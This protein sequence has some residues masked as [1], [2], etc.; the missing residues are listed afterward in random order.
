MP[1]KAAK[2]PAKPKEPAEV[3]NLQ[4]DIRDAHIVLSVDKHDFH[5]E[6]D[7]VAQLRRELDAAFV[8]LH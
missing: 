7:Q 6:P 2:A 8:A 4:V 3:E 5:L 1:T